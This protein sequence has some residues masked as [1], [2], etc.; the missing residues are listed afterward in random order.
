MT[1][2]SSIQSAPQSAG[3]S[4]PSKRSRAAPRST[5]QFGLGHGDISAIAAEPC[6]PTASSRIHRLLGP[7]WPSSRAARFAH[8]RERAQ[9]RRC[10][11]PLVP[12]RR[13]AD[14]G[15]QLGSCAGRR[16]PGRGGNPDRATAEKGSNP[17]RT[18]R[19]AAPSI[20]RD[21]EHRGRRRR[22]RRQG[23]PPTAAK[24]RSVVLARA[25]ASPSAWAAAAVLPQRSTARPQ[26][27][28][29]PRNSGPA[30]SS[31]S[32]SQRAGGRRRYGNGNGDQANRSRHG[33]Q[34]CVLRVQPVAAS[35]LRRSF[36]NAR[37]ACR[38]DTP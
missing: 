27:A 12:A 36:V 15:M 5:A 25:R 29:R 6:A 1:T 38:S 8:G 10:R 35:S 31:G 24:R 2:A 33:A 26:G 3:Y 21:P 32:P 14:D 22:T 17:P 28:S 4:L 11:P 23:T 30:T 19:L 34:Q 20:V 37:S 18:R 7:C 16:A 13:S 9:Q